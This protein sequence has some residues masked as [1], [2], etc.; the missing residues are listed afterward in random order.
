[1]KV[2]LVGVGGVGEAIAVMAKTRP[3]LEKMVLADYSLERAR[4]IQV[5]LDDLE[6]FPV[7]QLDASNVNQVMQIARKH[8]VD[9]L[10]NA[11]NV[12]FDAPLFEAA[13]QTG[14]IYMD[15]AM[16]GLGADMGKE[17]FALHDRWVEKGL[18]AI[19][20]T[21]ADPGMSD[22]FARYARIIYL[23]RSKRSVCATVLH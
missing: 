13:Y 18:L 4:K 8:Q 11:V 9:L 5:K 3:W 15:M 16:N 6:R 12:E 22:V 23:T 19:R 14:C 20:A 2:F 17:E 21:G 1:M 7:E 10:M